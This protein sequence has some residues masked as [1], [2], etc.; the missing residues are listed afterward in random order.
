MGHTKSDEATARPEIFR[1]IGTTDVQYDILDQDGTLASGDCKPNH[2]SETDEYVCLYTVGGSDN[3]AFTV[4]VGTNS[5]DEARNALAAAYTHA[6]TLTL[7]TVAPAAPVS[8]GATAGDAQVELTWSEPSPA[9]ASIA[10]WQVRHKSSGSY[11]SWA[12]VSGGASARSHTVT[13]LENGTAYT[14]QVR[15]VDAADNEGAAGTAGPSTPQAADTTPPTISTLAISS[16]PPAGQNGHYGIGDA[17]A[18]TATFSEALVLSGTPTL[19]IKVGAVE[20]SADCAL[21]GTSGDDAKKLVCSYTVAEGDADTDG[22][23]VEAGKLA[24]TIKD[25]ADNAATLTY[26]AVPDSSGHKV[27]GVK[28]TVTA[29]ST[30]YFS[31][32][33]ATTALTGPQKSAADIFTKVTFSEDMGHVK[34]DGSA[35]RPELFHRIGSTDTRYDILNHGDTLASGD[36]KP[37]DASETDEYVCRY[38]VGGSDN[39]AFTVKVG[40][41]SADEA[42][43]ALAAEYTHSDTLRLDTT[44]P[45]VTAGSTGY[46]SDA[47][48]SNALTEPQKSGAEIYTKVTFSEDMGH[49]K[50]DE[51][52]A[53]PEIFRRIGTTDVQYD[54]LNHGG[55]LASGDCKPNDASETDEYVCLYTVGG[56]DN[57]AFTVKVG[58]NSADEARNALAAAYTHATTLTLDTVA[59]AAPVSLGATAGAAQVELTWS[60]PSPADASIA[61]WQV[62]HKSSGSYGS[63]ADVSGGASARSHTVTSLENGTAYTFQVRAVDAADNEGAAGTAGP[64]TPQAADT[65]PPTISTLAISSS[66]PAG[67]NGHYR[68]G[69]AVAVTATFSEALV[70]SGTPTLKI[71]VGAV[72]KSADCALKGTSGDDAK[73][74]VCSYTVAE[75]DADTDGVSVE[76][77]KLAGTIKDGADN[78]ATLTYTAVPDS[79]GHKV[80]GVKPTI[81]TLAI[82][83]SPRPNTDSQY[84]IGDTIKVTA[85][86]SEAIVVTGTPTL[87]IKVGTV[88]KT[89]NCAKKGTTGDDA[90]KLVCSYTVAEGDADTNGVAVEA[91]KLA[92]TIKDGAD[93]AATLTYTAISDSSGHKVDGVRPTITMFSLGHSIPIVYSAKAVSSSVRVSVSFSEAVNVTGSP[94]LAVKIGDAT[95]NFRF[96]SGGQEF[97]TKK[98]DYSIQSGDNDADGISIDAGS[99]TLPSGASI[100][101]GADND[102]VVTYSAWPAQ[103]IA[104]VDTTV[105]GIAFPSGAPRVGTRYTITLSDAIAKV[106][107]Y[108]FIRVAGTATDATGCDDPSSGG[109]NFTTH[110]V[111]TPASTVSL[112]YTPVAADVGKKLCVYAEDTAKNRTSSLWTTAIAAAG[113]TPPPAPQTGQKLVSN[114][115]QTLSVQETA[116]RGC[117]PVIHHRQ[118][119]P[120]VRADRRGAGDPAHVTRRRRPTPSQSTPT[121]PAVRA[122]AW[123]R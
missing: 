43:N 90:K 25:G 4:K 101:D 103:S 79:S 45:T 121:R 88:E 53:R 99:L 14:F 87:K 8:L 118:R 32:A 84:A 93:N 107:K 108:G 16:S 81:S 50:S 77:G 78:A 17:V 59:P 112:H 60:E 63:W 44:A 39:G 6:T 86:F 61:K 119:E 19:K 27:D 68:I 73:K 120:G 113:T 115:A 100:K 11:G 62:R 10:K 117:R 38:T 12:D 41:G 105:P 75:G 1:R 97:S 74:L 49:T 66:P 21:K 5:A 65:T 52:T 116:F 69:D 35:G 48:L 15:A 30:G 123:A 26:T 122:A 29:G 18:V 40:T 83:S 71:K 23:S 102:A 111:R 98:F 110:S 37:T 64:S 54:I 76:A 47:A 89:A 67:Q 3:G 33:A 24:G 58:T 13:S 92:G 31:D 42:S 9:D 91:G 94:T 104:K 46:Y 55:T 85:T 34:G 36:C 70:L 28:P 109:D 72:E 82:S 106:A 95:R 56:S 7:D 96:G 51:A 80:D 20:K 57:G 22:V 114:T 2:A